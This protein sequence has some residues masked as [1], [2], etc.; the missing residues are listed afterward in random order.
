VDREALLCRSL[1]WTCEQTCDHLVMRVWGIGS[2][3][4]QC[5]TRSKYSLFTNKE[6]SDLV[7]KAIKYLSLAL[8]QGHVLLN[9][10]A[11]GLLSFRVHCLLT[12][13]IIPNMIHW[14]CI[15]RHL[16]ICHQW[17]HGDYSY[18]TQELITIILH[19]VTHIKNCQLK[20]SLLF[21]RILHIQKLDKRNNIIFRNIL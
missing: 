2:C 17:R 12:F 4:C 8:C 20:S 13:S 6:V 10:L 21:R 7:G 18:I 16:K 3:S 9:A 5:R 19:W 14:C 15:T 11:G 1:T